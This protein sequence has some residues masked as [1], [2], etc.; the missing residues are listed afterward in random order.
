HTMATLGDKIVLFGGEQDANHILADTWEYD[1]ASW[2]Q[3]TVP[4]PGKRYHHGMTTLG[5]KLVLFGGDPGAGTST[6]FLADTWEWDG[7]TWT[8]LNVKGP[9]GRYAYTMATR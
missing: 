4:G 7:A 5:S 2:T 6:P 1:G 8:P 3:K 9:S